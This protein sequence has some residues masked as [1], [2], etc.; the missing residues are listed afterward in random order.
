MEQH[1]ADKPAPGVM[2]GLSSTNVYKHQVTHDVI[3]QV[4]TVCSSTT[5]YDIFTTFGL[6]LAIYRRA[7]QL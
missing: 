3:K 5:S 2:A 1:H 7:K 4:R 6:S